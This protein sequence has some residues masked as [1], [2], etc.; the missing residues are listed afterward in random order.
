MYLKYSKKK[1]KIKYVGGVLHL[2]NS[3]QARNREKDEIGTAS[4]HGGHRRRGE[5]PWN[6]TTYSSSNTAAY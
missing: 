4:R 2:S 1:I 6:V 3:L 5:H